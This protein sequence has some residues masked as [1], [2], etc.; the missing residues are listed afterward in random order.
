MFSEHP[1]DLLSDFGNDWK[2]K[3]EFTNTS[4]EEVDVFIEYIRKN[5]GHSKVL[6]Q[7]LII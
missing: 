1:F 5:A 6:S 4:S 2:L 7:F 3:R